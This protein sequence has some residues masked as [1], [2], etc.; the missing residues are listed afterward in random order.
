[1]RGPL[2]V[3]LVLS[4]ATGCAVSHQSALNPAG[5]QAGSIA[6]LWWFFLVLLGAIFVIVVALTAAS[7]FR[8]NPSVSTD[9]TERKLTRVVGAAT[10]A[11][12]LI[13]LGLIA[14]SVLTGR[15]TEGNTAPGKHLV[16]EVTGNQWWWAIRYPNDDP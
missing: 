16:V 9:Q 3:A 7:L 4:S 12:V 8:A 15:A 6:E 10:I 14:T 5:R 13:L 11:T 1:M 2:A